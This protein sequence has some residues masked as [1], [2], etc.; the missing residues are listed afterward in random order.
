MG[1]RG[2]EM[3]EASESDEGILLRPIRRS[4]LVREN[5]FWVHTGKMAD[6]FDWQQLLPDL[7]EERLR[8]I[9]G[10]IDPAEE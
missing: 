9:P 3:V 6:G 1:F 10:P 5:G 8:K 4:S 2:G 7:R